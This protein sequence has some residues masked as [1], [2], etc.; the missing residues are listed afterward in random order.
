MVPSTMPSSLGAGDDRGTQIEVYQRGA[1]NI[2]NAG[3]VGMGL[4]PSQ[5]SYSPTHFAVATP[6]SEEQIYAIGKREGWITRKCDRGG[7]F[8]VIEFWL[9]NKFM[10]ELL[11]EAEQIRYKALW[12]NPH[13]GEILRGVSTARQ[14]A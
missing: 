10:L 1:E 5:P 12:Q 13:I 4:N 7:V 8:N 3:S 11:T 6:L 14:Q 9:E 2:P